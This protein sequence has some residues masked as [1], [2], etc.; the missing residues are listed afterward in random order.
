MAA[1]GTYRD[2]IELASQTVR[3]A[4]MPDIELCNVLTE[5]GAGIR[6][7][8]DRLDAAEREIAKRDEEQAARLRW[9]QD[10]IAAL[11]ACLVVCREAR[12]LLRGE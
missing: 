7:L 4:T 11:E 12:R 10:H 8:G 2:H 6:S 1:V 3:A 5:A 9:F